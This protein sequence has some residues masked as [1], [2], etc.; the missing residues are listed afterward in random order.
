MITPVKKLVTA[1]RLLTTLQ[2]P[3]GDSLRYISNGAQRIYTK[4]TINRVAA[5]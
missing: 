2:L 4:I 5:A 3:R 1:R